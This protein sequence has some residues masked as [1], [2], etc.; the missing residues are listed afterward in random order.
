MFLCPITGHAVF[1]DVV[2][3]IVSGQL[4]RCEYS[5][6]INNCNSVLEETKTKS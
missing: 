1:S 4:A 5:L 3:I 6:L 2:R